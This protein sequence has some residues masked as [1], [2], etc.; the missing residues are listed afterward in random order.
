VLDALKPESVIQ[1]LLEYQF[2][3]VLTGVQRNTKRNT[4]R[5]GLF[6]NLLILIADK[7]EG[8]SFRGERFNHDFYFKYIGWTFL[9]T[10]VQRV[11]K[12]G[13]LNGSKNGT[14]K[15]KKN[16]RRQKIGKAE[17]ERET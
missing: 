16:K 11:R 9:K 5:Y 8:R 13:S 1:L 2:L 6:S 7:P 12:R 3:L 4:N 17:K 15:K 14:F 10:A